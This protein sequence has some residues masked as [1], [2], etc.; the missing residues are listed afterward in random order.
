MYTVSKSLHRQRPEIKCE[1]DLSE[2]PP[3]I[4]V[5]IMTHVEPTRYCVM[6]MV[7]WMHYD[8]VMD[9]IWSAKTPILTHRQRDTLY[10]ISIGDTHS[11]P[12]I[13][14]RV[15]LTDRT[16]S[17]PMMN[18]YT[19]L[20]ERSLPPP[21]TERLHRNIIMKH[22]KLVVLEYLRINKSACAMIDP[23]DDM[24]WKREIDKFYG[25]RAIPY[26]I[27]DHDTTITS[28]VYASSAGLEDGLCMVHTGTGFRYIRHPKCEVSNN[29]TIEISPGDDW[30]P[31]IDLNSIMA[32]TQNIDIISKMVLQILSNKRGPYLIVSPYREIC[33]KLPVKI[34]QSHEDILTMGV[35]DIAVI[36]M[37]P[38]GKISTTIHTIGY[39][40]NIATVIFIHPVK[41]GSMGTLRTIMK[42]I[43]T[44][45]NHHPEITVY[46]LCRDLGEMLQHKASFS[47][48][49]REDVNRLIVP[50][51][52]ISGEI[53][54]DQLMALSP[55]EALTI[56]RS[57]DV[58]DH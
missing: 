46:S 41:F 26:V 11:T 7:S 56:I 37:I 28:M 53:T 58:S 55:D 38:M 23:G 29:E 44:G 47:S 17:V 10:T 21:I 52:M 30:I 24:M 57:D 32:K 25:S 43:Q 33:N 19:P 20:T 35:R 5:S 8:I 1:I 9:L 54:D 2:L 6:K 34:P 18:R 31:N 27:L 15:P 49:Y 36:L 12:M 14:N 42:C 16:H 48:L 4:I 51:M 50:R 40:P 39:M 13:D 3:E 45:N 22:S